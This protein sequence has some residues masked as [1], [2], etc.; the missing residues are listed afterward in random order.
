MDK[1]RITA[2]LVGAWALAASALA[3]TAQAE[4]KV[5]NV[6]NW[7]DYIDEQI[8]EDFTEETGIKVVYDVYDSN[9]ILETKLLAGSSGYDVVVP[10]DRLPR[11]PDRGRRLPAAR[12]V[13]APESRQPGPE[14]DGQASANY[15]PGNEYAVIYMWGTTG[16]GYNETRSSSACP[17]RRSIRGRC[18]STRRSPPSSRTAASMCSISPTT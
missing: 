9:E 3:A 8:L 12:Q 6:Y 16:I 18:C 5:V 17:M 15:D 7:S 1:T 2:W 10:T 11:P 14:S 13:E 4:E